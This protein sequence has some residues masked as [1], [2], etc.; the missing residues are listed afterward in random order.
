MNK[1]ITRLNYLKNT[2]TNIVKCILFCILVVKFETQMRL[3][4]ATIRTVMLN[5]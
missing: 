3:L 1:I 2:T 4:F 5:S